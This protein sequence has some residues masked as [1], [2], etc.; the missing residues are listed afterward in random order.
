MFIVPCYCYVSA[1]IVVMLRYF[2]FN[3]PSG[4]DFALDFQLHW[5]TTDVISHQ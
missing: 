5:T 3:N 1:T 4:V 2:F